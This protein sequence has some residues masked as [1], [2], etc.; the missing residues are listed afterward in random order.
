[1][2]R[3]SVLT[4]VLMLSI[5]LLIP[6]LAGT[7]DPDYL[8]LLENLD[9]DGTLNVI[10]DLASDPFEG[11]LSGAKPA[12]L[13]SEYVTAKFSSIGLRP[14][15]EEGTYKTRFSVPM[16]QLTKMPKLDLVDASGNV[17]Q[18]FEYRRDFAIQPGSGSGEFL[19]EV[20]FVG[21]GI[22]TKDLS[23]DDYAGVSLEAKMALAIVGT[24]PGERFKKDD[25]ASWSSK[26]DNALKHGA[27]AL[28]LVDNP[29]EPVPNYIVR[30]SGGRT[31]Y[32]KLAIL[33]GAIKMAD[34]LVRDQG[35]SLLSIQGTIDRELRPRPFATK[36]HLHVSIQVSYDGNAAAYNVLGMI[37]GSDVN[38]KKVVIIGAHYDHLGKDV[39]G[40]IFRGANDDASGVAVMIEIAR[41]LSKATRPR[42]SILFAS[43]SGEEEGLRGSYAYVNQPY[44]PLAETIAYL[45][46]DMV[47]AG[48]QLNCQ[49]SEAHK[50]LGVA[51]TESI[52]QL[53]V[54]VHVEGFSGGSDHVPFERNRVANLMFICW[55]DE[56][57]HTP[58][59]TLNHISRERLLETSRVTALITLKLVNAK[60]AFPTLNSATMTSTGVAVT[61][62][63]LTTPQKTTMRGVETTADTSTTSSVQAFAIEVWAVVGVSLIVIS[64]GVAMYFKGKRRLNPVPRHALLRGH[65][66]NMSQTQTFS[67]I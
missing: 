19:T 51:L 60:V 64:A 40:K 20:V 11:R 1:M 35:S 38:S 6:A 27:A 12:E 45:N 8:K 53:H 58:A 37:P 62:T 9:M 48:R 31:I 24:P 63:V 50:E 65:V 49:I 33:W 10:G 28:I 32:Q 47:G 36:K 5:S 59:D 57:Y 56:V 41:V 15:G 61:S 44:V 42:F 46:L 30:W 7:G 34:V 16:W 25:Y 18:A 4:I 29:V 14:A 52:E 23:Y 43:W 2:K 21:Y 39:D 17:V 22:T 26:A 66:S 54:S 3:A 13:A 55:P 67:V